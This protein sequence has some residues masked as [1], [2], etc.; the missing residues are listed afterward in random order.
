MVAFF[1]EYNRGCHSEHN[2]DLRS[3][4][5]CHQDFKHNINNP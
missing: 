4:H 3:K 1:V 5:E 2:E